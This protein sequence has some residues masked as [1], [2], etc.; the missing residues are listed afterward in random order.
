MNK[1]VTRA[2]ILVNGKILLGKRAGGRGAGQYALVGGKPEGKESPEDTIVREV[3]EELGILLKNVKPWKT[4]LGKESFPGEVWDAY[5][6]YGEGEGPL[7]LK[8]NEIL[9]VI[10]VGKN[11]LSKYDIAFDHKSILEEFFDEAIS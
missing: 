2:I 8:K 3:H 11:D 4:I 10:Y 9:D 1:V 7:N 5:F 6:F